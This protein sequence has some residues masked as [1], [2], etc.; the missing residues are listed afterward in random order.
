MKLAEALK[1]VQADAVDG[2]D[3][4]CVYLACG[5][6]P[7]HVA[8]FL[9]AHLKLRLPHRA[10]K[11]E[12]GLYGDLRGNLTQLQNSS[13]HAGA[14]VIEWSDLDPRLGLRRLG[15][16]GPAVLPDIQ[17]SVEP[18]ANESLD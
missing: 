16:W 3:E 15:G 9:R 17:A 12:T 7:L 4:F 11:I 14:V 8:T 6:L 5:I 1:L 10:I 18:P 13:S 2:A